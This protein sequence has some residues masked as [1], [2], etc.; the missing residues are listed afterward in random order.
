ME[1]YLDVLFGFLKQL[2]D[3]NLEALSFLKL[4]SPEAYLG[5]MTFYCVVIALVIYGFIKFF[6]WQDRNL[7]QKIDDPDFERSYCKTNGVAKVYCGVVSSA[8]VC[9]FVAVYL[10]TMLFTF[11]GVSKNDV[12]VL[13]IF[14]FALVSFF[15]TGSLLAH[16]AHRRNISNKTGNI[17]YF[18]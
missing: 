3:F 13:Q 6:Q 18:K 8:A 9:V 10:T 16:F 11:F 5:L 7:P 4:N 1:K 17:K 12:M 15:C 2:H 14:G